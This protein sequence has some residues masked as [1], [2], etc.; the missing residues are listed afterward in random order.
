MREEA[1]GLAVGPRWSVP[2]LFL[3]LGIWGAL[4]AVGDT[5]HGADGPPQV[6]YDLRCRKH[7]MAGKAEARQDALFDDLTLGV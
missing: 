4:I 6:S 5:Q 3:D 7:W 2:R 1:R